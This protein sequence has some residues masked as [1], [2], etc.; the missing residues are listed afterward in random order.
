ML[1]CCSCCLVMRM[2][3][4]FKQV[5]VYLLTSI[6]SRLVAFQ[7]HEL[8]QN[9]EIIYINLVIHSKSIVI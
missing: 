5:S 7:F 9:P 8:P 6:F 4:F 1:S 3:H 2:F